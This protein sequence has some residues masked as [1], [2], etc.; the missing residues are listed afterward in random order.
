MDFK[1]FS[2]L[3]EE[4]YYAEDYYSSLDYGRVKKRKTQIAKS[5]ERIRS[6]IKSKFDRELG[7][8]KEYDYYD[9]F[10]YLTSKIASG[11]L[12]VTAKL[13]DFLFAPDKKEGD[14][15]SNIKGKDEEKDTKVNFERWKSSLSP[16]T[17]MQDLEKFAEETQKSGMK[18]FG[19]DF[20]PSKPKSA[21]EKRFVALMR[22]G[23]NEILDRM[24]S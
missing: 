18:R 19:K 7:N 4:S 6:G 1:T 13:T 10:S 24:K 21:A 12:G 9:S 2:S 15:K 8:K 20:D 5:L 22:R 14:E 16:E 23:E 11:A 17:T 3:N